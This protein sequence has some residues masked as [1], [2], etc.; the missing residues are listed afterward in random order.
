L[1]LVHLLLIPFGPDCSGFGNTELAAGL[2]I[3]MT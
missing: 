1:N 2:F 3:R